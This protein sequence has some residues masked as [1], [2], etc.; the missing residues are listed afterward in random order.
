MSDDYD[1]VH[2]HMELRNLKDGINQQDCQV[3]QLMSS[4]CMKILYIPCTARSFDVTVQVIVAV[5]I[6]Y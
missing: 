4:N 6:I 3:M 5:E 1:V 2:L